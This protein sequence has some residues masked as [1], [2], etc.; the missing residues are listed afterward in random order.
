MT[1]FFLAAVVL[2]AVACSGDPYSTFKWTGASGIVLLPTTASLSNTQ[3]FDINNRG[4]IVGNS[5]ASFQMYSVRP[6]RWTADKGI[7]D[8]GTL[9][10][11][12]EGSAVSI[13][14]NGQIAGY[15]SDV[16]YYDASV[17]NAVLWESGSVV[18]ISK[19]A[20]CYALAGA[21][22]KNGQVTGIYSGKVFLWTRADGLQLIDAPPASY[23]SAPDI[24][25][26]GWLIVNQFDPGPSLQTALVWTPSFGARSLGTLPG[27][28]NA[29]ASAI[30]DKG[31]IVGGSW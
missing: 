14:D 11:H 8:L 22:N 12:L 5:I 26:E 16:D 18:D 21:I 30:N 31:E 19:C 28:A 20:D 27:A 4:E 17:M 25:S 24:N 15:S 7:E 1:R 2:S 29:R 3:A 13:N 10:G 9:P 6:V 23:W